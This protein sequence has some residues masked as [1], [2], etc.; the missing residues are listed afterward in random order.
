MFTR[1]NPSGYGV[2][3]IFPS[4]D[5][6]QIDLNLSRAVDGY[7]G[8]AYTPSAALSITYPTGS[9]ETF[10]SGSVIALASGLEATIASRDT[11]TGFGPADFDS[12]FSAGARDFVTVNDGSNCYSEA[13]EVGGSQQIIS[14][15]TASLPQVATIIGYTVNL[16]GAPGAHA[17]IPGTMPTLK[18]WRQSEY[19]VLTLLDS[20]A[21]PETDKDDYEIAHSFGKSGL[22]LAV[23]SG[24]G[25]V[26]VTLDNE[27]GTYQQAGLRVNRIFLLYSLGYLVFS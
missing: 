13:Q 12:S 16:R 23:R 10:Q 9:T 27:A 3:V 25:Q 14:V 26:I 17:G 22:S 5:A 11:F 6:N 4:A 1:A 8:G 7:A 15:G 18:V 24:S 19:G 2:G 20:M 21:D